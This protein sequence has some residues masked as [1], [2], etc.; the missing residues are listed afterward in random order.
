MFLKED[1]LNLR[2]KNPKVFKPCICIISFVLELV[3]YTITHMVTLVEIT[4]NNNQYPQDWFKTH[5]VT[6]SVKIC[7]I[8][9]ATN[10]FGEMVLCFAKQWFVVNNKGLWHVSQP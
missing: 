1:K 6:T 10:Y 2:Q 3:L 5:W 8:F 4:F 7:D 9:C